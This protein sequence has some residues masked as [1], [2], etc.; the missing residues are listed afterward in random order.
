MG[1]DPLEIRNEQELDAALRTRE[2]GRVTK[3]VARLRRGRVSFRGFRPEGRGRQ[4]WPPRGDR[5]EAS[6]H[7]KHEPQNGRMPRTRPAQAAVPRR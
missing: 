1:W 4:G 3:L 7:V 5:T 6:G 2:M